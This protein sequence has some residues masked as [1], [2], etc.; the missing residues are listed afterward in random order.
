M[1]ERIDRRLLPRRRGWV[2]LLPLLFLVLMMV[3]IGVVMGEFSKVPMTIVFAVTGAVSLFTLR[4][5]HVEDRV[6][7]FSWLRLDRG[8]RDQV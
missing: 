3:V 5:Y 7:V 1:N 8:D 4:G 6:K 2:A